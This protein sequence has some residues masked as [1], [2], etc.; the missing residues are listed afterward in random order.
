M[1]RMYDP[2]TM[3]LNVDKFILSALED[4]TSSEDETP[5]A[6][7]PDSAPGEVDLV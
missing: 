5:K 4:D 2:I 6:V 1:K 7:M 3:K